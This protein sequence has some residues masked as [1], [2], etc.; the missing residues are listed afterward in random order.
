MEPQTPA[1]F[2]PKKSLD[3]GM[4][5]RGSGAAGGLLFLIGLFLFVVSVTAAGA[6]FAYKGYLKT[7]I[8]DKSD[9]LQKAKDAFDLAAIEDLSRI[10]LRIK[11]AQVLL[12]KHI[13]PS[14]IFSFLSLQTLQNVQF[15]SFNY[16]LQDDGSAAIDLEG[17]AASFSTVA[18]Q[19]DQFAASKALKDIVF[20][21]IKV[22]TNGKITF[23]V[24]ATID[25]SLISYARNLTVAPTIPVVPV[26]TSAAT[27]TPT[28]AATTS[29]L[30]P[31][32]PRPASTTPSL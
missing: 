13:A 18:L 9:S 10:D 26:Q 12:Q 3:G 7:S 11:Q 30:T 23:S 16:G 29:A 6:V 21:N 32:T 1:S 19:S 27:T 4:R 5:S 15:A 25:P 24:K 2:I 28:T 22:E 20:S 14:A 31:T 8:A 17:V